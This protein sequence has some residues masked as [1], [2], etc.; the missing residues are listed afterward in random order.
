MNRPVVT[1]ALVVLT[2]VTV[3]ILVGSAMNDPD[4]GPSATEPSTEAV[5]PVPRPT[6]PAETPSETLSAVEAP[7]ETDS[8]QVATAT[9]GGSATPAVTNIS[10]DES[11]LEQRLVEGINDRRS[12]PL[13]NDAFDESLSETS[14]TGRILTRIAG[15]HSERMAAQRKASPIAG[16]MDTR[17][18][19]EKA[20]IYQRCRL[21][22]EKNAFVRPVTDLELVT[23]VDPNGANATRTAETVVDYWFDLLGPRDTLYMDN[24]DHIGVGAATADGVVYVTVNLC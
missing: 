20:G 22:N 7:P 12:D 9:P 21:R 5:T 6:A 19:Y 3:P 10:I 11:R 16:G 18:R 14:K 2:A 24:A 8:E 1:L 17:D 13:E 23:S 4:K 15:N